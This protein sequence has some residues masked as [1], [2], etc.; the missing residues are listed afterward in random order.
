MRVAKCRLPAVLFA[1]LVLVTAADALPPRRALTVGWHDELNETA[2]WTPFPQ[3][4]EAEVLVPRYGTMRLRIQPSAAQKPAPAFYWATVHRVAEVDLDRYP[5][6]AV[7]TLGL[8]RGAWW[9]TMVQETQN[10][11]LVGSE[12]KTDSSR[13]AHLLLFDLPNKTGLTGR[14]QVRIRLN[15]GRVAPGGWADYAY[16]R[17]V[18]REGAEV[19]RRRPNLQKVVVAP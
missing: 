17:F 10:G 11:A 15:V 4:H 12:H 8:S 7:R 19:L 2:V 5:I 13:K 14:R 16:V 1:V 6:M 3:P 18:S 9:D